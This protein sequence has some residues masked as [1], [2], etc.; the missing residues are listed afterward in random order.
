MKIQEDDFDFGLSGTNA[1]IERRERG[2]R[3]ER[4]KRERRERETCGFVRHFPARGM[5]LGTEAVNLSIASHSGL[6]CFIVGLL[7]ALF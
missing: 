4:E 5:C 6:I 3:G 2:E 7:F 1:E